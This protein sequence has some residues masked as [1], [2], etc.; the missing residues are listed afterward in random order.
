MQGT[1]RGLCRPLA[2]ALRCVTLTIVD[3]DTA[4]AH[5]RESHLP[6][7]GISCNAARRIA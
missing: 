2:T 4:R 5:L 3:G 1:L 6:A 7:A